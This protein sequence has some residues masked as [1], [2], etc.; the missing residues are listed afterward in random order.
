MH[1]KIQRRIQRYGWDLAARH[2]ERCWRAHLE[3]PQAALFALA[4]PGGQ[5]L[6]IACGTGLVA[7]QAAR[8]VGPGGEVLGIDL[9]ARMV[10]RARHNAAR[11][12]LANARFERMDAEALACPD[13]SF[14]LAYC[15]FGLMYMPESE[16]ALGEL[17]RVLRPGGRVAL[18]VWGEGSNCGWSAIFPIINA[19]ISGEACPLFYRL[20]WQGELARLCAQA[21]FTDVH[22]QRAPF[23]LDFAN[24]EEACDAVLVG[25]PVALAWSRFDEA[26][27]A[28]V[29]ARYRDAIAPWRRDAGYRIPAEY[30]A[31]TAAVPGT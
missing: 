7:C 4:P 30:L 1:P 26:V 10:E 28:R 22:Q 12:G 25:G 20:G 29:R 17:R 15:G 19:E 16:R 6:D 13:A 5:M 11:L 9:S 31:V 18:T 24:A 14:D 8:A 21:G 2:Y 27:R 23:M 3:E